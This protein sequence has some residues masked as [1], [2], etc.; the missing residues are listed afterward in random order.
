MA[1]PASEEHVEVQ[2]EGTSTRLK[3][4]IDSH[5]EKVHPQSIAAKEHPCTHLSVTAT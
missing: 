5:K 3:V 2:G 4:V 1:R